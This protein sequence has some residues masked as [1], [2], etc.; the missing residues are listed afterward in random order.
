M[1]GSADVRAE[2]ELGVSL[3]PMSWLMLAEPEAA[4]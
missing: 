2:Y 1:S 4:M 3:L